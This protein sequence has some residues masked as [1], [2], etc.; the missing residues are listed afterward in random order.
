MSLFEL[1][2]AYLFYSLKFQS[3]L[4]T[5]ILFWLDL[6]DVEL[7]PQHL[8]PRHLSAA[9]IWGCMISA[10]R[11]DLYQNRW[12]QLW[13]F[14]SFLVTCSAE[15]SQYLWS[16]NVME[17]FTF[18][19]LFLFVLHFCAYTGGISLWGQHLSR[20]HPCV[21]TVFKTTLL[22]QLFQ[23]RYDLL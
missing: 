4:R 18:L 2:L 16:I 3:V 12:Q 17:S 23:S 9:Q 7:Q 20:W 13:S 22:D 15:F 6:R 14:Y 5:G 10:Y 11:G 21:L 8:H 1:S 19:Y